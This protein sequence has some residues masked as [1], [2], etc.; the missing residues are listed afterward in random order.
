MED[1]MGGNI[2]KNIATSIPKDRIEPTIKAYTKALGE[3]FPMKAHSLT[4][5]EPVG[6]AGKKPISGDLDLAIDSTHIARSFTSTELQKWGIEWDDWNDLYGKIHKRSRT[7]TYEMSKMR[8]LLTLISAKIAENN[9]E[10]NDRVTAGNI[11]TCFEQH[12]DNGPTGE[13]VQIDWM[14]GDIDWLQWSYYSHGEI[15][16]KGLHRTQFLVA[17]FSEIGYTFSHFSGIKKKKTS[18]WTI[19]SPQDALELLSE[20]YG[21]VTHSQTQTFAQLHSWLLKADSEAYF[22][23]ISRYREILR[24]QKENIP[25]VLRHTI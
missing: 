3:I 4:F 24:I 2:F 21:M 15:N 11:F 8:A 10:V 5:F 23:V 19:T 12:N 7:A 13:F 14:V 16:L 1:N 9:I 6:S 17:L 18:E 25:N 20:H 22:R